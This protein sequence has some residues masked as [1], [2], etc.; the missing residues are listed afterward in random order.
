MTDKAYIVAYGR[1]PIGKGKENGYF[2]HDKPE[3][4][5]KQVLEGVLQRVGG[6]FDLASIDDLILGC[7]LPENMQGMNM[8]RRLSLRAGLPATV[9]GMTLTRFCAS[10]LEAIALAANQVKVGQVSSVIAGGLEFMS[11]SGVS[12]CELSAN[13]QLETV[14]PSLSTSMGM[15]AENIAERYNI[16]RA[17]QDQFGV[18]S[19]YKAAR[20][21][22]EGY[23]AREIIPLE[24]TVITY[25]ENHY[26]TLDKHLIDTDE[27]VRPD[28]TI[29]AV[30]KLRPVFKQE[31]TVT[32]ATSSQVSDGAGF[33][34]VMSEERI[35]EDG[36]EPI[37]VFLGYQVVGLDPD[38]MGMGP[39][40]AVRAVL[41]Q[42]G[43]ALEDMDVI[44]LNEAFA[45]QALAVINELGLDPDRVNPNGGAIALGHPTGATGAILVAKVLSELE[46][47][48]GRYGLVTMC[49]GGGMGA[50]AI[51][52]YV[53]S[54]KEGRAND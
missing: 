34:V 52:E 48:G 41:K 19:H 43:L 17:E 20:A 31:G 45:A 3:E 30:S 35:A 36:I 7:S 53:G 32:A 18:S 24:A 23:F 10:G 28:T 11:T 14:G 29:E 42:T 44:E 6:S 5:G 13:W 46:R 54:P 26:P 47:I 15:T 4:I 21:Q 9:P 8:A 39:V 22:E 16:S 33:V 1:S 49:V 12:V 2:A 37:G 40:E 51:V 27:G 25:D 50:A 38:Y